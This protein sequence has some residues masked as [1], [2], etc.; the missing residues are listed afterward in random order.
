MPQIKILITLILF[1]IFLL[2]TDLTSVT[3]EHKIFT[4]IFAVELFKRKN[5]P[6]LII[7][8]RTRIKLLENLG[9]INSSTKIDKEIIES[10]DA[11]CSST[12][13][14]EIRV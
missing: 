14:F 3:Q 12:N 5:S 4:C 2:L 7:A 13:I 11:I 10:T 9:L 8:K 1:H 6:Q